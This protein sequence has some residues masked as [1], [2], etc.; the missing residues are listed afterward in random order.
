MQISSKH[1][2]ITGAGRRLGRAI[3]E[4]L[5]PYKI[6]LTAHFQTSE[7]QA[8]EISQKV[9]GFGGDAITV[10][11]DLH[12]KD[13]CENLAAAAI[14]KFGPVEILINSAS[15]FYPTPLGSVTESQWDDLMDVN[16]K[17]QFFLSQACAVALKAA[18]KPGVFINLVD[19][20]AVRTL[21]NYTPYVCSK[22]GLA[23]LTRN[24]SRELAPHIRVNAISPGPVLLP[25]NYTQQQ[26]ERSIEK[27]LL[28][29]LGSAEDIANAAVF[30]I[31]ND[32]ITGQ[33][34]AVDGGRSLV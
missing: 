19:V 15:V 20:N 30:L 12:S 4:R 33:D 11:A 8:I 21:A 7:T 16:L 9:K 25:E 6:N 3:A 28:K 22:A 29:R 23:M 2:L 17:G 13:Q 26:K 18:H 32:Y 1:V 14:K 34:L 5:A 27:T 31:E 24:L 10:Q